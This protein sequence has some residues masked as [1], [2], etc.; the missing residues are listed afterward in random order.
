MKNIDRSTIELVIKFGLVGFLGFICNYIILKY[1][2]DQFGTNTVVAEIIAAIIAL[3]VTFFAN[4]KW[5][6]EQVRVDSKLSLS[7][8]RRYSLYILSNS[9]G[10]IYTVLFFAL[11]SNFLPRLPALGLAAIIAMLWNFFVNKL[12]IWKKSESL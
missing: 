5:T 3:Q 9:L 7:I 12:V 4:D 6:Y 2:Q 1:L 10:S 8:V 11:F